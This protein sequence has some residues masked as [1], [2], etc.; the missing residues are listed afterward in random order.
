M[1]ETDLL[2][3]A[4]VSTTG[5]AILLILYRVIKFVQGKKLVS[6]CCG[7]KLEVGIDVA[8]MTPKETIIDVVNPMTEKKESQ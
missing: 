2:K 8:P 1:E 5:I 4:G 7:K 3:M 6:N